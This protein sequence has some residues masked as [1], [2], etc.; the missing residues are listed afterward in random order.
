MHQQIRDRIY[1]ELLVARLKP[2]DQEKYEQV[3]AADKTLF[4]EFGRANALD[5]YKQETCL[6]PGGNRDYP[7]V[8]FSL[9]QPYGIKIANSTAADSLSTLWD[10]Y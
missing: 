1:D 6:M 9:N 4:G 3:K 7:C 2:E 8:P 5:F 10:S